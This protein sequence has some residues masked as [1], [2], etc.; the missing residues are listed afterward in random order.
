LWIGVFSASA[1]TDLYVS[2]KY[3]IMQGSTSDTVTHFTLVIPENEVVQFQARIGTTTLTPRWVQR[4]GHQASAWDV[5]RLSFDGLSPNNTYELEVLKDGKVR[6]RRHF[7]TQDL[8]ARQ[9]HVAL[10]SCALRQ[11]HNPLMWQALG[12]NRNR[13]N[14][15]IFTGDAVYLDRDRSIWRAEP[16]RDS[17]DVWNAYVNTRNTLGFYYWETLVPT[18]ATWD[19][20]DAGGDDVNA[21][22]FPLM[23]EVRRVFQLFFANED[24]PGFFEKGDA[25]SSQFNLFGKHWIIMD[26]RS[27]REQETISPEWGSD[28]V[29][30]MFNSLKPGPNFLVNGSQF[31]GKFL[32]KDAVE[33]NFPTFFDQFVTRLRDVGQKRGAQVAFLSGDI[34]FSEIQR[35]EPEKLGY[36]TYEITSS[37]VHSF[38]APGHHLLKPNNPRQIDATGTHNVVLLG[39]SEQST[40]FEFNVRSL[41]WRDIT[42]FERQIRV[43]S[44]PQP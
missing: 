34:H 18:L 5:Y 11:F 44:E 40:G 23:P 13:P 8:K 24:I 39:F 15:V 31:F 19:D 25:V 37:S 2:P 1:G 20:H 36:T 9:G 22:N 16:P 14:L 6:D 41:G 26:G 21:I 32:E 29:D 7:R 10:V 43:G 4:E 30:W 38:A 28:Q 33:Y 17:A 42:L 12:S 3:S 27:R 35:I